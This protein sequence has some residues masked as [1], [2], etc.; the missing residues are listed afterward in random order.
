MIDT[1]TKMCSIALGPWFYFPINPELRSK[2][3]V[4]PARNLSLEQLLSGAQ[5][6]AKGLL[7]RK[8]N[9]PCT[10]PTIV[11]MAAMLLLT[12]S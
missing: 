3:T 11:R 8:E 2:N 12:L 1:P 6:L 10:Q 9:E 5:W 7:L 4:A